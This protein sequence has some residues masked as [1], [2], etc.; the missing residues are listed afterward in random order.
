MAK[1][2]NYQPTPVDEHRPDK[3]LER[4]L[5]SMSEAGLLRLLS[6]LLSER[7]RVS[8]TALAALEEHQG[9]QGLDNLLIL[10]K[11]LS[12]LD[13][14]LLHAGMVRV[15]HGLNRGQY[16]NIVEEHDPGVLGLMKRMGD[17]DVRRGLNLMLDVLAALGGAVNRPE[18]AKK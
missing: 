7:H 2:L 12:H 11:A 16:Q 10:I 1:P 9:K 3:E 4:L 18:D 13:S 15:T 8:A 17:P 6:N 5:Q 14:D